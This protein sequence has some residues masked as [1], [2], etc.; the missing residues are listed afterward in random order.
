M[1]TFDNKSGYDHG[2]LSE[3]SYTYFGIQFG[4]YFMTYATL[5]FGWKGSAFL[6]QT[7]GMGQGDEYLLKFLNG[8]ASP[9][10][11]SSRSPRHDR[12]VV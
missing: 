8:K 1:V 11:I 10:F 6:Y 4:G 3:S 5:P 2:K 7:I 12:D 9:L